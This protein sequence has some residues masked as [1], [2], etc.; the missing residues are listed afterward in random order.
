MHDNRIEASCLF[1]A[2][3]TPTSFKKEKRKKKK[4]SERWDEVE[5][6]GSDSIF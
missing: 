4:T 2:K 3:R 6:T 1:G 5:R